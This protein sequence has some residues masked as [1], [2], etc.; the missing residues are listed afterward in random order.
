MIAA[1]RTLP[2]ASMV[3]TRSFLEGRV[4]SSIRGTW[5]H[6][7]ACRAPEPPSRQSN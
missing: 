7:Q 6:A 5:E 1:S 2:P 3:Q 4:T